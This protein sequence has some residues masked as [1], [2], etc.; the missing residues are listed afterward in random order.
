MKACRERTPGT[1]SRV[2]NEKDI[3]GV[4]QRDEH[5]MTSTGAFEVP[6]RE[7][8]GTRSDGILAPTPEYSVAFLLLIKVFIHHNIKSFKLVGS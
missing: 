6:E 5:D 3:R 8:R 1:Q 2:G 4:L 7:A